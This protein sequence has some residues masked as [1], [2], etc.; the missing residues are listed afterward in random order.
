VNRGIDIGIRLVFPDFLEDGIR[1]VKDS[2]IQDGFGAALRTAVDQTLQLGRQA[3]D[4]AIRGFRN[5]P[6]AIQLLDNGMLQN[7]IAKT[8]DEAIT[9]MGSN[10]DINPEIAKKM[11]ERKTNNIGKC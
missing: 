7:N 9:K 2:L 5:T 3:L 8:V 4:F 10:R 1:E 11:L 6:E